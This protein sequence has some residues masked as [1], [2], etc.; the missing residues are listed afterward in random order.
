MNEYTRTHRHTQIHL[1]C[2][3][4]RRTRAA[5]AAVLL[6][7]CMAYGL[8]WLALACLAGIHSVYLIFH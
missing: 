8:A 3:R 7:A 2:L 5:A 4:L 1:Q 6:L